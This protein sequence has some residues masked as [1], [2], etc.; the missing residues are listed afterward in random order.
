MKNHKNHKHYQR[1]MPENIMAVQLEKLVKI[2]KHDRR[3]E[4]K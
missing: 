4:K 1:N 3:K 2:R